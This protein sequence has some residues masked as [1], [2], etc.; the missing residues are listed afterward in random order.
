MSV[1]KAFY[2]IISSVSH[3]QLCFTKAL[4][5]AIDVLKKEVQRQREEKEV[6][7]ANVREQVVSEM[8]EII[9][10][11]QNGFRYVIVVGH[12]AFY[13]RKQASFVLWNKRDKK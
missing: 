4:L 11:M 3:C 13:N 2:T 7:E 6:L 1:Q 10:E 8:Q 12:Y 5:Q 9:S